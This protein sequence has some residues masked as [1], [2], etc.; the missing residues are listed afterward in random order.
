MNFFAARV[1]ARIVGAVP[2]SVK[3][4]TDSV[5]RAVALVQ[6][7]RFLWILVDKTGVQMLFWLPAAGLD[8]RR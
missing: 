1:E 4:W 7:F 8:F 3:T 5:K 2:V 6:Y